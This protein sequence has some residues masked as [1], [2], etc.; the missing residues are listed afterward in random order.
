MFWDELFVFPLLTYR[1][2]VLTRALLNYRFRRLGE[3]RWA[4]A[5]AG[6]EGAMYPWQSGSDGREE[7]QTLH[8]NPRSGR[9]LPDH[10]RLQRHIGL[11]V[12]FNA[13]HYFQVT[14]H[15]EFLRFRGP[16]ML[17]EIARFWAS[18]ASFD[19][20]SGR[21]VI[22]GVM[23]PDEYHD[24]YPDRVEPGVDNNAYTNVKVVW[25]LCRTLDLLERLPEHHRRELWE[26]FRLSREEV[27]R[28]EHISRTMFVPFDGQIISQFEGY[29][30]LAELDWDGLRTRYVDVSRM[31]RILEAEGDTTNRYQVSKQA[32]VLM[33]FYLLSADELRGLF[34]RL[35]YELTADAIRSNVDFYLARTSHGSTLSRIVHSWVLGRSDRE[36]S[37]ELFSQ[38]LESD[39]ADIQG[40]TTPEGIHLGAMA[41]TVDLLQRGYTG[42]EA[43]ATCCG[44][45]RRCRKRW[46]PSS[47]GSTTAA[48]GSRSGS[49]GIACGSARSRAPS[50]R[51][52]SA[53]ATRSSSWVPARPPSG[54]SAGRSPRLRRDPG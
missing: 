13:W 22:R 45:T 42:L 54:R 50:P 35:G 5:A 33:L 3:A 30:D 8:L 41:G 49:R 19:E 2:P 34:E 11:A 36:R 24:G 9:W 38:A 29:G 44:S 14:E 1:L 31:D 51:S 18:L 20:A 25:L 46:T 48:T 28:W 39:V 53:S 47:S 4:A 27:D 12:A 23:G 16:P 40:G 15:L 6:V 21:H 32:D 7:S 17:I 52:G 43:R 37:W 26:T 10:T